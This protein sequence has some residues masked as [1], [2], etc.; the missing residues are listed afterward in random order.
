MSGEKKTMSFCGSDNN[1]YKIVVAFDDYN[2]SLCI[3]Y[4]HI[5]YNSLKWE[6]KF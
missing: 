6:V 3:Y 1:V 5:M 2:F 4:I